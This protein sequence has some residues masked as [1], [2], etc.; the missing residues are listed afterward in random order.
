MYAR[1]VIGE[2]LILAL[3]NTRP[4]GRDGLVDLLATPRDL[5][6]WLTMQA[7]RLGHLNRKRRSDAADLTAVH[8]VRDQAATAIAAARRGARPPSK[9]LRGLNAAMEAARPVSVL[10]WDGSRVSV[11]V[12]WSGP[13]PLQLA[14]VFARAAAEVLTDP[15][16]T[17]I[18]ECEAE[19]CV[20]VF[21]P[22]H[23]N[24][25]WCSAARCGNRDR[26]ARYYRRHRDYR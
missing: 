3:I 20:M 12:R 17:D 8:A 13:A 24:R 4:I 22:A 11:A 2:L 5:D 23:P 10:D 6:E 26:V 1:P 15:H 7:P 18:R 14:G 21:L 16:I 25:R 9:A 19:N